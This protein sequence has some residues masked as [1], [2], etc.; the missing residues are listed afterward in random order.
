MGEKRQMNDI[1]YVW[2]LVRFC[3]ICFVF[4]QADVFKLTVLFISGRWQILVSRLMIYILI[5]SYI[6][7]PLFY[8]LQN[9]RDDW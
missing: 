4:C 6:T 9:D 2:Q 1:P 5:H 3:F 7:A 8:P